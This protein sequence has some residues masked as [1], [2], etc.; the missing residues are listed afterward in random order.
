MLNSADTVFGLKHTIAQDQSHVLGFALQLSVQRIK[1]LV[2]FLGLCAGVSAIT[3]SLRF[4]A[5]S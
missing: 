2:Q 4:A 5:H 3:Q 1:A